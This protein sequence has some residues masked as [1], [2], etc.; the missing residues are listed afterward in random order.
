MPVALGFGSLYNHS[1]TLNARYEDVNGHMKNYVAIRDIQAGEEV[2]INYN[3]DANSTEPVW[4]D[5]IESNA[6][7]ARKSPKTKP[8]AVPQKSSRTK[9]DAATAK[10]RK[11]TAV[12]T[13]RSPKKNSKLKA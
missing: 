10:S 3:G 7:A 1:Y 8:A 4:F 12:A 13:K 6:E 11:P 9:P 2:M 5:V